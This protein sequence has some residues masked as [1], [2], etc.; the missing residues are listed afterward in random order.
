MSNKL[1]IG[2][3]PYRITEEELKNAFSDHGQPSEVKIITDRA[4]GRSR[5]FGF[6]SYSTNEE[7]KRALA[8]DGREV[9]GRPL[10]VK[11]A[12]Q[13]EMRATERV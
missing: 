4:T 10:R 13:S 5:G 1:Y 6:V 7:A 12:E 3:L 9:Q 8:M 11:I 2:N